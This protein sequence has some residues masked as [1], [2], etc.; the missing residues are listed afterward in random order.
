MKKI[1]LYPF[2]LS[3]LLCLAGCADEDPFGSSSAKGEN[4][5]VA[6]IEG[7]ETDVVS[8]TA[9]DETGRVTWIATD[10]LGVYAAHTKNALFS[11][12]GSGASVVFKGN[13]SPNDDA[14]EWAYY[15][16]DAHAVVNG[17]AL[18]FTLPDE[19]TY[20]GNSH[21]P[22]LAM[23]GSEG[24]FEFKHLCGLLRITLGGGMPSDADRFVISSV[25]DDAPALS[26]VATV[27][28]VT[29]ADATL[30]LSE[31]GGRTVTY[32]LGSLS[33]AE[34]FQHFFVPLPVG[35]Y[36]KLQVAFY[37][38]DK[39]EPE[40][41][42]TLSNLQVRRAV[43]T[44]MPILD[45]RTGEQFVLNEN[46]I[47][48]TDALA[49]QVSVSPED[50]T[51]LLYRATAADAVPNVGNVV[52]SRVSDDF[53][54]GFLGKVTKVTA[55]GDGSYTVETGVASLSEAFDEL[56]IEE[57]VELELEESLSAK[58]R[59]GKSEIFG[60]NI[61]GECDI[62]VGMEN[63]P[64]YATGNM[65]YGCELKTTIFFDKKNKIERAAFTLA[66]ATA[67]KFGIAM[68]GTF[69]GDK[70][71][72]R[73][74][75]GKLKFANIPLAGGIIQ[76]TPAIAPHFVIKANGEIK[77]GATF[78]SE[79]VVYTG[80]EYNNGNWLVGQNKR[81]KAK[82]ESPWNFDGHLTFA[83]ELS[84]G[85]SSD[86]EVALYNRD[87][88][89]IAFVP[90]LDAKLSG[91]IKIDKENSDSLEEIL[92][93]L[94]LTTSFVGAGKIAID[95][96]LLSPKQQLK[97]ELSI[98]SCEFGHKE[99]YLLPFFRD[100]FAEPK[101]TEKDNGVSALQAEVVT[102]AERELLAETEITLEVVNE[103][104]ELIQTSEPVAYVGKPQGET[105]VSP[106]EPPVEV[107]PVP[108][109]TSFNDLPVT[110]TYKA[111]PVVQSPLLKDIV[112]EG[113]LKLRNLEVT[114]KAP[115]SIRDQLI[116]IY[117]DTDGDNW[118]NNEN[119][120]TDEPI[121]NWYGVHSSGQ[122]KYE[123]ILPEN[124]LTGTFSLSSPDIMG[125]ELRNN[126]LTAI[127]VGDCTNLEHFGYSGNPL[128]LLD[129]SK[130]NSLQNFHLFDLPQLKTFKARQNSK[131]TSLSF[132]NSSLEVLDVNG[133]ENLTDCQFPNEKTL[134][135]VNIGACKALQNDPLSFIWEHPIEILD[136]SGLSY[137]SM[138]SISL[139]E[140]LEEL[141]VNDCNSLQLITNAVSTGGG[142]NIPS[143]LR[144]LEARNSIGMEQIYCVNNQLTLLDVRNSSVKSIFCNNDD[145]HIKQG[146]MV[147]HIT[148]CPNLE[149]LNCSSNQLTELNLAGCIG[150]TSLNC[151][152]NELSNL[153]LSDNHNLVSLYVN[154]NHLSDIDV[155]P[156]YDLEELSCDGNPM[157]SL[158]VSG[159]RSLKSL[160]CGGT[161]LNPNLNFTSLTLNN[162]ELE[163]FYCTYSGL[164]S[165]DLSK[166]KYLK[167]VQCA[168][169]PLKSLNL[170]GCTSLE[171]VSCNDNELI[172]LNVDQC[173]ALKILD[174]SDNQIKSLDL[175]D[176]NSFVD[177]RCSNNQ[178]TELEVGAFLDLK[179]LI[180]GIN[181]ITALNVKGLS[182]LSS[183]SY[184]GNN[185]ESIDATGCI[186]LETLDGD[187]NPTKKLILNDCQSLKRIDF[188]E[189]PLEILDLTGCVGLTDIFLRGVQLTS[190][191]VSSCSSLQVLD[192]AENI[193]LATL[194]LPE[195][196][197]S[198]FSRMAVQDTRITRE[199]P[200]WL[201]FK[202]GQ[203]EQR[204]TDYKITY[205]QGEKQV[206]YTDKG[207]G[208]WYPGEPDKGYHRA[209]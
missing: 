162:P 140:T 137:P 120:C 143:N 76:L 100:L 209:N 121:E 9:V 139:P 78:D 134:R 66:Q 98:V 18:S 204:Y 154:G 94:K 67:L 107:T 180:C 61:N 117:K 171:N 95:A 55:N 82:G 146:A 105:I 128:T 102:E 28:D 101:L 27:D 88:M 36:P 38:K 109:G 77:S 186:N 11:S 15:P 196:G 179:T 172:E 4:S 129:I 87:D 153:D 141:Y 115:S 12:T 6:V 149:Y 158:D 152:H 49:K 148:G 194:L 126:S 144:I 1:S 19:Y 56:C 62:K 73:H 43:M 17:Q 118:T 197:L 45:W 164:T 44:C 108:I 183:L 168:Y 3:A 138:I 50:N 119:W 53:P 155:T 156:C 60:F 40:F 123:I 26:G 31:E 111:Y 163:D 201:T 112:P 34:N 25:G 169:N 104:D 90:E 33:S 114:F 191:D 161:G 207:Y 84:A 14:A 75:L 63:Y 199:I 8:R 133:C 20:T 52:W 96:S 113:K 68:D 80:A 71:E 157:S 47:E 2:I 86:C 205:V 59:A 10:A 135:S 192:C 130:C 187:V 74:P 22:M 85:L 203:Y 23:K 166:Y 181:K 200:N 132:Y 124:N 185:I 159:N 48:I 190:L 103:E 69:A 51:T 131:V 16:Y 178:L 165:L 57:T 188:R 189:T 208:W 93:S 83:G 58:S 46:T 202:S 167:R 89:K 184:R 24:R 206:T 5:L 160:S 142:G 7:Q 151:F 13:L 145:D 65:Q 110:E 97:A 182:K 174:C 195:D 127:N 64:A 42:R 72:I 79:I 92:E 173:Y 54:Y 175:N 136:A 193:S 198:N 32:T 147:L 176:C 41:T 116:Q 122:G 21:A 30:A 106:E 37:K 70:D 29:A 91:E 125:L 81:N 150:L 177:L 170:S 35:S 99:L 39:S